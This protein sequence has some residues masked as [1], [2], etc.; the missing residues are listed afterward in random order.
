MARNVALPP[1]QSLQRSMLESSPPA[2]LVPSTCALLSR[3]VWQHAQLRSGKKKTPW[4]FPSPRRHTIWWGTAVDQIRRRIGPSS[5]I[6]ASDTAPA[7]P[8]LRLLLLVFFPSTPRLYEPFPA[9]FALKSMPKCHQHNRP[10]LTAKGERAHPRY[11]RT[12]LLVLHRLPTAHPCNSP[13]AIT[14]DRS[15]TARA[16]KKCLTS[17]ASSRFPVL[18]R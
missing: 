11:L 6:W 1:P 12:R 10:V 5:T 2:C 8:A 15:R 18:S 16:Q 9:S 13:S 17:L 14:A 7:V 3:R 4:D